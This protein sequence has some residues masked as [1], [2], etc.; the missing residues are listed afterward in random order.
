M[1]QNISET[2]Q[3]LESHVLNLHGSGKTALGP[4]AVI[5]TSAASKLGAGSKVIICTDGLSNVGIGN[6][7][8]LAKG[9]VKQDEIDVFYNKLAT[10]A[11]ESGVIIDLISLKGEEWDLETL[12]TLSEKT[13]GN[14]DIIN[15]DDVKHKLKNL[16]F[17]ETIA[18][19]V[20][21]KIHLHKA[22]E[23]RNENPI[24]LN[25]DRTQL[26]KKLG[27]INEDSE[28]TFE[29]KFKNQSELS[30]LSGFN[31]DE[32][33]QVPFQIVIEYSTPNGMKWLRVITNVQ[34]T[35]DDLNEVQ[36]DVKV[37]ILASNAAH[38]ATKIARAGNF[39]EAQA[40]SMKQ[41]KLILSNARSDK[42]QKMYAAWKGSMNDIYNNMH[43]QNNLEERVQISS[44]VK[45]K[46]GVALK[47]N[48]RGYL[49]KANDNFI[50]Y[51][52]KGMNINSRAF[53]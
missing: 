4:A 13:G 47:T 12:I 3:K 30:K 10:F 15:P 14:V 32:F 48:K 49:S 21:V 38:Q 43:I 8:D 45:G 44:V 18:T 51:M 6:L 16:I 23:F 39:R 27:S 42:Q 31:I 34:K 52:N 33:D 36:K 26:T 41:K 35:N 7:Q 53:V 1:T 50:N 9:I 17:K 37:E 25:K 28:I 20:C 2:Y 40:Y 29:Y 19:K 11:N 22:L 24:Q 46:S 5:A